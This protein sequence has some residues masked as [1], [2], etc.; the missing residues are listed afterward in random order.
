ME[1]TALNVR[2]RENI[3]VIPYPI[4]TDNFNLDDWWM[5]PIGLKLAVS[6]YVKYLWYRGMRL[7]T[8]G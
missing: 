8:G 1:N 2:S 7:G 4:E 5:S 3:E 6:E